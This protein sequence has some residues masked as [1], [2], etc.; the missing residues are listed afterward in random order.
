MTPTK[1][2][3][4]AIFESQDRYLVPLFQRPYVWDKE[5]QWQP[6][7]EDVLE[8]ARRLRNRVG[9]QRHFLG[10]FVVQ[11]MGENIGEIRR[12]SVI[13]GQQRLTTLQVLLASVYGVLADKGYSDL[14]NQVRS[15]IENKP[16]SRWNPQIDRHKV[17]PTNADRNT[18]MVAMDVGGAGTD[19]SNAGLLNAARAFFDEAVSLYLDDNPTED[20]ALYLTEAITRGLELVSIRLDADEDPQAIFETL[21]ARGKPLTPADLIKNFVFQ[22]IRGNESETEEKYLTY[23]Q[24]LEDVW[25]GEQ[26]T[27]GRITHPRLTWFLWHWLRARLAR[28]FPIGSLFYEFRQFAVDNVDTIL[29]QIAVAASRYREVVEGATVKDG[30]LTREQWLTYRLASLGVEV[31]RPLLL[32]L[33]ES[34]QAAITDI[35]RTRMLRMLE[36]YLV[37]RALVA[38]PSQGQNRFFMELLIHLSK[39][40]SEDVAQETER[41]LSAGRLTTNF[42]PDDQQVREAINRV[43]FYNRYRTAIMRMILES[44]EDDR[45]GYPDGTALALAPVRRGVAEIEHI[46]P[47]N[48]RENWQ[49][50]DWPDEEQGALSDKRDSELHALGN[51]TL[52]TGKLNK[53]L[54][55]QA[56]SEKVARYKQHNDV[57]LTNDVLFNNPVTWNE[58]GI[59]VRT[60]DLTNKILAI[61]PVPSG[62]IGV[63]NEL[64][65]KQREYRTTTVWQVDLLRCLEQLSD[66]FTLKEVYAFADELRKLH[67]ENHTIED[68]IRE[69]LQ[70]L[71]KKKFISFL[72]NGKYR[73]N[74]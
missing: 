7:W 33:D 36:S 50:C 39:V 12:W 42:W 2:S 16:T 21:N 14:A 44:L 65:Q 69:Q 71:R 3:P 63:A 17:W 70:V 40:P 38:A 1:Q 58:A 73:K 13:D 72:G 20:D 22:N 48:W 51:L 66:E 5:N 64:G 61:W 26:S 34:E 54:S 25:W 4:Q 9:A 47:K 15:L 18:F 35:D 29:P 59:A 53:K 43:R 55:N 46:M 32:W 74:S 19:N 8:L 31:A 56:W 37:R 23:W 41:Y 60:Q 27:Q 24:P 57:Q 45:R 62:H 52:V 30:V 28:D 67:P 11:P 6:L 10:A 68:K 49:V